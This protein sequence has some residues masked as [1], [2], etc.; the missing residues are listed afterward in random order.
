MKRGHKIF[1]TVTVL[2][3]A[4][5]FVAGRAGMYG[6]DVF[7]GETIALLR[8]EGPI[9]DVRWYLDQ[10]HDL[11]IDDSIKAVVLRI[12]S[13]GGAVA[14]TQE[15]YEELLKLGEVKPVV[16]SMGTVA[17]SGGYYLSCA[18]DWIV[19]NP[20]TLTGS[21]GVIMEFTN[22]E[23]LFG[24]LGISSRIIKSGKFKD[25]GNPLRPMTAEEAELLQGMIMDTYEQFVEAVLKGRPVEEDKIRPYLDGRVLTG[26]QA[27]DIGLVD[28]MGNIND[29]IA[30]ATELAGLAEVPAEIYEPRRARPGLISILFGD[31]AARALAGLSEAVRDRSSDRWLQLWRAF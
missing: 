12:D 8:V 26:R 27:L 18:T 15:L 5:A 6:P 9:V 20:G 16:T 24:K 1:I 17:A 25:T 4:L 13:P 28:Q 14:P 31:S 7:A 2:V 21:V 11:E 19:S 30:K 23:D 22:L 10:V 29:A 3:L